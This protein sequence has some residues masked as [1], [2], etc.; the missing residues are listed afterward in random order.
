MSG[1]YT[2]LKRMCIS[3][4]K[5]LLDPQITAEPTYLAEKE[6]RKM[7]KNG[8]NCQSPDHIHHKNVHHFS[9][10]ANSGL[11]RGAVGT[12]SPLKK[13]KFCA[14]SAGPRAC[15]TFGCSLLSSFLQ[16]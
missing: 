6:Y 5:H 12:Y 2:K 15:W 4:L 16:L 11:A 14:L 9:P 3:L 13:E 7:V 1:S 10:L 8:E